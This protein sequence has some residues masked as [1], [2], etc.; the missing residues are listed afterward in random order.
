MHIVQTRP[1]NMRQI[2]YFKWFMAWYSM[3]ALDML[4]KNLTLQSLLLEHFIAMFTF[5]PHRYS[6]YQNVRICQKSPL[7]SLLFRTETLKKWPCMDFCHGASDKYIIPCT[8]SSSRS[9][10]FVN[11]TKGYKLFQH[12]KMIFNLYIMVKWP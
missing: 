11:T 4:T 2:R 6:L 9:E 5:G 10:R 7:R 1:I 3:H 8:G 12:I